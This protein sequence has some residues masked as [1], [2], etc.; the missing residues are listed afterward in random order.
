MAELTEYQAKIQSLL[1]ELAAYGDS[2]REVESQLV[3]M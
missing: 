2:D 1:T 3:L